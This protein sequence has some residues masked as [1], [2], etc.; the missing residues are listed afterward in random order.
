MYLGGMAEIQV[1]CLVHFLEYLLS[2]VMAKLGFY[3]YLKYKYNK[4]IGEI[5]QNNML[6]FQDIDY[7]GNLSLKTKAMPLYLRKINRRE[8]HFYLFIFCLQESGY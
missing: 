8:K 3:Y 2:L 7:N 1:N 6:N 4:I 5:D